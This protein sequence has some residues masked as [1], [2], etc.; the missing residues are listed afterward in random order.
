MNWHAKT[1]A[2][3]SK[4]ELYAIFKAR[5]DVFVVEQN[6]P[7]PEIDDIDIADHTQHLFLLSGNEL[8][9]YARCYRKSDTCAAIGRVLVAAPAR[10][11]GIAK[12]L[13]LRAIECCEQHIAHQQLEIAAQCYLDGFYTE[14]GFVKQ[15]E[16]Y[17]EDGIP[18]QDMVLRK[19][20]VK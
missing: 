6:C 5:V 15:G 2:Q 18:H 17:L 4:D 3:L 7:Y 1:Y 8:M 9:A 11:K 19:S 20:T 16:E 13:M 12:N 10:G 14:L